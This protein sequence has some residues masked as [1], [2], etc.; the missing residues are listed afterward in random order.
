MIELS[1]HIES[2]LLEHNC[3]I[4]PN[5]GGFV[6]Q[7][8]SAAYIEEENLFLPPYRDVAF[9]PLLQANDGLLVQSYMNATGASYSETQRAIETAVADLKHKIEENQSAELNGIGVLR[10]AGNGQYEFDPVLGGVVAP[11]YFGLDS[12]IAKPIAEITTNETQAVAA[13]K[14]NAPRNYYTLHLHKGA[15]KSVAAAAIAT[16]FYILWPIAFNGNNENTLAETPAEETTKT[17]VI[18]AKMAQSPQ[19]ATFASSAK[20]IIPAELKDIVEEVVTDAEL[21][22]AILQKMEQKLEQKNEKNKIINIE[23]VVAIPENEA[24]VHL[25]PKITT[26]PSFVLV[27][28]SQVSHTGARDLVNKMKKRDFKDVS[29]WKSGKVR[30][31]IFG[32]YPSQEA[33]N[34]ALKSLRPQHP[35]FKEAWVLKL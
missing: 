27:L 6:A 34:S 12:V 20:T 28:A 21:D 30:R 35:A 15:I 31:V 5:L 18:S 2:L 33:A 14:E 29:V 10:L 19:T 9:N 8:C 11:T 23:Q 26:A 22:T 3:V 1:R 24:S 13:K 4:I 32:N 16:I 25:A 17:N 7:D